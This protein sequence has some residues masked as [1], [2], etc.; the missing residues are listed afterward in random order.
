[1]LGQSIAHYKVT[2]KLGAGGMGEV[3]RA[4]DEKLDRDVALK[5]LPPDSFHDATARA[6]LLREAKAAAALN[7][8]HICTIHEVGEAGGRAYIAMELVEGQPLSRR[9]ALGALPGEQ[10]LRYGRQIADAL[11][12]AHERGVIHRDLKC[13]NVVVTGDGRTKVLDFGLAKRMAE[14]EL[15]EATRSQISLA[16]PGTIAGTLAYMAPEQLRGVPAD[17]RSDIWALGVVLYEMATGARPFAGQPGFALSSAILNQAP[18]PLPKRVPVGLRAVIERC[19]EKEPARRYQ[20]ASETQAALEAIQTGAAAPWT[21]WQYL[22][23]RPPGWLLAAVAVALLT[24]GFLVWRARQTQEGREPLLAV[25]LTTQPGVQRYPSFSPDGNYVAFTWTGPKQDNPDVYVQQIGA[26]SPLRLTTDS[27]DDYS[28][29]WSP[30]GRWIAFLRRRWETDTSELRMI[31]PLG[32]P[33]RRVAEI[34]LP[35]SSIWP[36]YLAWCPESTCF[37]V[38]DTPGQGQ[39]TALFVVS[40]ETGEKRQLTH[41][42]LPAAGDTNPAV[43]PDGN[44]LVFRRNVSGPFSGELYRLALGK[45]LTA[46]GQEQR[47]TSSE[48]DAG[49][50]TWTPDSKEILFSVTDRGLWKLAV[51]GEKPGEPGRLPFVGEDGQ[52]PVVSRPQPGRASRLVY[53]RSFRDSNFWQ[54]ETVDTGAAALSPPLVS[55]LSSTRR[56]YHPEFSPDGRQVAFGS[57]RSGES[58]IWVADADGSNA[59]QLTTGAIGAGFPRWSPDGQRIVYLARPE[60]QW[61]VFVVPAAG[62]K[63]RNVTSHPAMDAWCTFSRDGQWI[64]FTSDRTGDFQVWKIATAGGEA[65]QLTRNGAGLPRES[66]DGAYLYYTQT[67]DKPSALWRLPLAGGAPV[68]VLAGVVLANYAVLEGGIYYVDRPAGPAGAFFI[69]PTAGETRLQYFDF[70]TRRS[71]TVAHNLGSVFIGLTTTPDGRRM[72]YTR[73]DSSTDNLMLVENY[74]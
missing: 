32:G 69:D 21:D 19:L 24:A 1:M 67:F 12:H 61:E 29:V 66:P 6:R 27:A 10:V 18:A 5:V 22:L 41:P 44:W 55:A 58:E 7:H 38:A 47:L 17:A 59:V 37:V 42:Q 33:E 71:K 13:A 74:R 35:N 72:L 49:H 14:N 36:P 20:R 53:I 45:G 26:G 64:Y 70:A 16:A 51:P 34:R 63:P 8:P 56:D 54:V 25:P 23:K 9:V 52:M 48:L 62:G 65:V 43:S 15:D 46:A 4:R 39:P 3:Y 68:K 28:A 60:G 31:P 73:L 11:G 2:A 30:D 57:D 50:P 40:L